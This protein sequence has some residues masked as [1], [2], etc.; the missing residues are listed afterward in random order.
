MKIKK[1]IS[2]FDLLKV[3]NMPHL[4]FLDFGCG[5]GDKVKFLRDNG[6]NFIGC[7]IEFK[8]GEF[9]KSLEK[10]NIITKISM[11]PYSLPFPRDHFDF[12]L[13]DQVFE[14]VLDYEEVLRELSRVGKSGCSSLHIFPSKWKVFEPH[15]GTP[16]GGAINFYLWILLWALL[17]VNKRKHKNKSRFEI[18][19]LDYEYIKDKTNYLP[20]SEIKKL[21]NKYGFSV[22]YC[23]NKAIKLSSKKFVSKFISLVPFS[24][25]LS[26]FFA[27]RFI[28]ATLKNSN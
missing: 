28:L 25:S 4:V 5:S 7:D 11:N 15:T 6:Y 20:G 16:F 17:G 14:H 24:S 21:F 12:V 3:P 9:T 1:L 22:Q 26:Q 18:A 2:L 8:S 10:E 23:N 27:G 19:K 13:S